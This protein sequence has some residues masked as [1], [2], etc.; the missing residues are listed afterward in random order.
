MDTTSLALDILYMGLLMV[1]DWGVWVCAGLIGL[2]F[3]DGLVSIIAV[4]KQP[5]R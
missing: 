5:R 3:L 4:L 2:A 1:G